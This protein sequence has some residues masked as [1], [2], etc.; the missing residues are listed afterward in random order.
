MFYR[1]RSHFRHTRY[2]L[3]DAMLTALMVIAGVEMLV[4]LARFLD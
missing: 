4:S 3:L 2:P 1:L